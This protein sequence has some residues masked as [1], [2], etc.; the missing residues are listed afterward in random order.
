[1]TPEILP[2]PPPRDLVFADGEV[3]IFC[4]SLDLPMA[5]VKPL[6]ETLS[7]EERRRAARFVFEQ[8]ANRFMAGRG[9]L[10]EILGH[11]L[12]VQPSRLNFFYGVRGKPQLT[13]PIKGRFLHFNLAHS[14]SLAVY[15]ISRE[16]EVGVDLEHIRPI[17]EVER[18]VAQF[19]SAGER[20]R[21][22]SLPDDKKTKAFFNCWTRKEALLKAG[23]DGLGEWLNQIE[24]LPISNELIEWTVSTGGLHKDKQWSL[25]SLTPITGYAMAVAVAG[26]CRRVRC[27]RWQSKHNFSWKNGTTAILGVQTQ[28]ETT[29]S[30]SSQHSP[31]KSAARTWKVERSN[32]Y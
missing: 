7:E 9:I 20:A 25:R 8:D 11:F 15:A 27:W 29:D 21:W 26:H 4:A 28:E 3:H 19:F 18:I 13:A 22:L 2:A 30:A 23:G 31:Q 5:R 32:F 24:V 14:D 12:H 17:C 1:M 16:H 6:A 10:R